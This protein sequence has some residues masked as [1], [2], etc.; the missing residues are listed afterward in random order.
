MHSDRAR[1]ARNECVVTPMRPPVPPTHRGRCEQNALSG[2]SFRTKIYWFGTQR[3]MILHTY[4]KLIKY[5]SSATW[6]QAVNH[7]F[8]TS[9]QAQNSHSHRLFHLLQYMMAF[10]STF[11]TEGGYSSPCLASTWQSR[12]DHTQRHSKIQLKK[13]WLKNT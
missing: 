9:V 12:N 5:R 2:T 8:D 6:R 7:R 3:S 11:H 10:F 1:P 4:I 13:L